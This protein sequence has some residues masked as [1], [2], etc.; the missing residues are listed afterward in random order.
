MPLLGLQ[1]DAVSHASDYFGPMIAD[2]A[3]LIESGLLYADDT[4]VELVSMCCCCCCDHECCFKACGTSG[5]YL[6]CACA[7][8]F[9]LRNALYPAWV[10]Q[11]QAQQQMKRSHTPQHSSSSSCCTI[12]TPPY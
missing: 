9:A 6:L 2:A 3:A 7:A 4:P 1:P 10:V 12:T 11:Q 5:C 8:L